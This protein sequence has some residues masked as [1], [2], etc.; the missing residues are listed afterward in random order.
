MASE[1][2]SYNVSMASLL[3]GVPVLVGAT[4]YYLYVNKKNNNDPATRGDS[5]STSNGNKADSLAKKQTPSQQVMQLKLTGNQ[6]FSRKNYD[7][8]KECYT[9][10]IDLSEQQGQTTKP[11]DLAIFYQNRAACNEALGNYDEVVI[12]CGHAIN[13]KKSYAKAYLR[14]ARAFDK[15]GKYDQAM[16]DAFSANLLEKFQNQAS[17]TLADTIVRASSS[18]KAAEAIK[19]HEPIWPSNQVIKTYFSSFTQ[20]PIN[21]KIKVDDIRTPEPLE[22]LYEESK[23]PENKD[24]PMFLLI[25]ASCLSLMSQSSEAIEVFNQIL[26]LGD[27]VCSPRIKANALLKKSAIII[28]DP[29]RAL[30]KDVELMNELVD[31]AAK[32]DPENPDIYLHKAQAMMLSEKYDEAI[33]ALDKALSLKSDY[34]AALAQ[35][36]Y[37]EFKI[38]TREAYSKDKL[39]DLLKKFETATAENPKSR[40]ILQVYSQVL[41]EL[42]HFEQADKVLVDMVK[43]DPSDGFTYVSRSLLKFHLNNDLDEAGSLLREALKKDPKLM[44]AYDVLGSIETQKGRY[45]EAIKVFETALSYC[46]TEDDYARCFSLLDSAKSQRTAAEMLGMPL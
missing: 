17:M 46:Q 6:N 10:A 45:D 14:R 33:V 43:V 16:V 40:D 2:K 4:W 25:K 19:K 15:L 36:L 37:L 22:P 24:D 44:L 12:D 11:E 29:S 5:A 20:D 31:R 30:E 3:I 41:T 38:S 34:L 13:L 27:D 39:Q 1:G 42:G 26:A 28:S 23:K 18:A 7:A 21:E 8:A 35:K 32:L 9:K